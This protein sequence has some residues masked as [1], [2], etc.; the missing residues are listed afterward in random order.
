MQQ[1]EYKSGYECPTCGDKDHR[2]KRGGLDGQTESIVDCDNC[3]GVGYYKKGEGLTQLDIR[4]S[5]CDST[6]KITCPTCFGKGSPS[7]VIPD[8]QKG[9]PTT[10]I[11]VSVGENVTR[12]KLGHR[13]LC[14]SFAGHG[15]DLV[16]VNLK[17]GKTEM[18]LIQ[19]ILEND[20]IARVHGGELEK[21]MVKKSMALH[22]TA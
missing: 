20:V 1:D 22:T 17:T 6:G 2:I 14:P 4:C 12:Y 21:R 10:G 5:H 8:D 18:A 7:V 9:R 13:V 15:L 16:G 19:I 11:V 3:N